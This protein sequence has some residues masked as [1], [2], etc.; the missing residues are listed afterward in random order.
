MIHNQIILF[1]LLLDM[2]NTKILYMM[3]I[4]N[5]KYVEDVDI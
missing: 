4:K 1:L 2:N 3:N 5:N